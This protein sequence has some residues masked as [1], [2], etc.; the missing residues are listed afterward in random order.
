MNAIVLGTARRHH[1]DRCADA[2]RTRLLD[3][4]PAVDSREHEVEDADVGPLV[5][6]ARE[7]RL[8]VRDADGV[9]TCCLEMAGHAT[10]DDVVV[11]ND[12]DFGHSVTDYGDLVGRT[13]PRNGWQPVT[14]W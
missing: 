3:D 8:A 4:S 6:K 11:L 12:Q 7:P 14:G 2:L 9:E 10:S 1:D 5:A 13:G